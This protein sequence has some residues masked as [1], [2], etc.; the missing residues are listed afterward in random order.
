MAFEPLRM[1]DDEVPHM[2]ASLSYRLINAFKSPL[3]KAE[4]HCGA[5]EANSGLGCSGEVA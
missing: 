1:L 2:R 5:S 3:L 4:A